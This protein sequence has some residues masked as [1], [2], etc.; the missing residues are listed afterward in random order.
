[1]RRLFAKLPI[2]SRVRAAVRP[3]A[4]VPLV[5]VA[6]YG[7]GLNAACATLAVRE[8]E[9][10]VLPL[11]GRIYGLPHARQL[12]QKAGNNKRVVI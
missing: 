8:V 9:Q 3:S 6:E 4:S 2:N 12:P 5:A 10:N 11:W 1:V 7:R